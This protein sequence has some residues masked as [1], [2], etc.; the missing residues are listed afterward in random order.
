[1][2]HL[3]FRLLLA[4]WLF[5][6]LCLIAPA[7]LLAQDGA[8]EISS[9]VEDDRGF[10]TRFLE[11]NLSDSGRK[12]EIEGFQGALRS[13]AT[14]TRLTIADEH[15][16]WITLEN[17]ALQ[18]TRSALLAGR[19]EINELSAE[20][21][22]LPRLPGSGGRRRP[23]AEAREFAL[24]Q[25]PVA[26]NINRISVGRV[27]LGEPIIGQA[28]VLAIEGAMNLADGQGQMTLAI[29]RVDG[30]RG[31]FKLDAGF[32]NETR[33]LRLDLTLDE[34]RN[35]LFSNIVRLDGRPSVQAE[36]SGEGP[37]SDFEARIR[38]ATDGQP[39]VTGTVSVG[40]AEQG[41]QPGTGFRLD[42]GGDVAALVP[43]QHRPFFGSQSRL[44]AEGWRGRDGALVLS[45]LEL[46]TEALK[47]SGSVATN[48]QGA[49]QSA[50]LTLLLG[51][52]AGATRLPVLL[53]LADRTTTVRSGNLRLDF[54]AAQGAGWVLKGRVG[55]IRRND[56][57]LSELRL[58]GRG[59]VG[60]TPD[61]ALAEIRGWLAFGMDGIEPA[62]PALAEA[63]S[64]NLNG[65]LSLA[66]TPGTALRLW[67]MNINGEDFTLKGETTVSG[68]RSGITLAGDITAE[69][70]NL[71]RFSALAGRPLGGSAQARIKGRYAILGNGFDIEAEA[72]GQDLSLGQAQA[73]RM[74][75]G[76]SRISLSALRD[77][78]G[79]DLRHLTVNAQNLTAQAQGRLDSHSSTLRAEIA[80][81]DLSVADPGMSG[82]FHT[83]ARLTGATGAR[84]LALSGTAQDL[85]IGIA[86]IDGALRGKTALDLAVA[87]QDGGFQLQSFQLHNP[88]LAA[89]GRGNFASGAMDAK[90]SFSM[91]DLAALGLG[92]S[93]GFTAEAQVLEQDG[94]RR[95]ALSGRG[96]DLRLG[97]QDLD[98][99]LTGT[100][101][102]R[103][104]AE[105]QGEQIT[106][107]E[108]EL[109]NR[110]MQASARGTL[111]PD[112]TDLTGRA[113]IASLAAFGRGWR[114]TLSAEGS[115]RDA[116]SG[117]R[118]LEITGSGSGLA[119]GQPR[120]DPLLAGPTSLSLSA[121]R[122]DDG[123]FSVERLRLQN[124]QLSVSGDG[125]PAG[126]L[127]LDARLHDLGLL[128]PA[129]PGPATVQGS[130]RNAGAHY[131]LDLNATGPGDARATVAGSVAAS[132]ASAN[133]EI[134]GS[135]NAAMA[136]TF[137]RTRSIEGPIGFDL[138]LN[139]RP[140]L[141]ALS[142]QVTLTGGRL[143]EPRLGLAVGNLN[144]RAD[145]AGGRIALDIRGEVE[146]GGTITVTGPI[147][148][149]GQ[150]SIDLAVRLADVVLRDPNLYQ[151]RLNGN[152]T[153]TGTLGAG[154]LVAGRIDLGHTELRIPSTGLGGAR[155]IPDIT[156]LNER[157]PQRQT[158]AKA[159]LLEYPSDASRAAGMSAP[160]ATPPVNPA[161][162]DLLISAPGQIFVRGRG[163]D[164]ELGGEIRLLGNAR[165]PIPVGRFELIRGRLDLLGRRFDLT[166]GLIELQGS[167][168]PMLRL[169]A[170]TERDG[171]TTR[172]IVDG[173]ARDPEITFESSPE[174]PQE[175]VL[176]Q[177]LFG[178]GVDR[179]SPLQAA[180]LASA[181]ATLA[182][183][184]GDGIVGRLRAATGLDDLDL[185]TDSRGR[186]SLRAGKYLTDNLYTDVQVGG[187]G[188]TQLNL[189][190]DVSP[191]LTARGSVDSGGESTFGLFYERDY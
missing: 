109:S 69:H 24:P 178:R 148:L 162:F 166:E 50:H 12:V 115:L 156:H 147:A 167:L 126:R 17:G 66:F 43:A 41:G 73:D 134:R 37:L 114:G 77:A 20:R 21:I 27:E 81:P 190:L 52:D 90:L 168:I 8:A 19:I 106:L 165:Q 171:V 18:W 85:A 163:V 124:P 88:Q 180:Q 14:F 39:R 74:L 146:A 6:G 177:L 15:G 182:G 33:V 5:P 58:D 49:P 94:L 86:A 78:S 61:L 92:F 137:L 64:D 133:L 23:Q 93:G 181:V 128:L 157:P 120:I 51:E 117:A 136:N 179:I 48:A 183:R 127:Q 36:I 25:L 4:L 28:A 70:R 119:L 95:I 47:L 141:E 144:A 38:L 45:S 142:G 151:T 91:P 84:E 72:L 2:H 79:I 82:A 154:P 16:V 123:S 131:E 26:V 100:T 11:E 102:L 30:P 172:I 108:F 68:L 159:G 160:P 118:R 176:S 110:Q 80:M 44:A 32:S 113:D 105:Q 31:H 189:N 87:Q 59:R 54:D 35:G 155:A 57:A 103:L 1:M 104:L 125:D 96:N 184:G 67:G 99:A 188:T 53:P 145:L 34:D 152:L 164:A 143:A 187:D 173:E 140:S 63:L 98:G 97:R 83:E 13:R 122:H 22:I 10:I 55:E 174:L 186:V 135:A 40:A 175:E 46:A 158:R 191:T 7:P 153:V 138:R 150:R 89:E 185:T 129:F 9:Q 71:A 107:H 112:G 60:T 75:A 111:G 42:L 121:L 76:Q 139:G 3:V 65:G 130:I 101:D 170:E 169:V 56:V 132:F 116:G 161:R 149:T 29:D 62:D